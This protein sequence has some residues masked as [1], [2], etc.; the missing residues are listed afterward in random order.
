MPYGIGIRR[1]PGSCTLEGMKTHD[2]MPADSARSPFAP[3]LLM[4]SVFG[5]L[6]YVLL[7]VL[8]SCATMAGLGEDIQKAGEEIEEAAY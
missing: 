1:W 7:F 8:T 2:R 4:L 6:I 5:I 3:R